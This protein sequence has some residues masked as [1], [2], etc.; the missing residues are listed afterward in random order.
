MIAIIIYGPPGSGKG[1]QAK[2]IADKLGLIHFDTGKYIEQIIYNQAN[3]N[4]KIIQQQRKLFDSGALCSSDWVF[5][6]VSQKIRQLALVGSSIIF[7]GSPRTMPEAFG[8]SFISASSK[9][10]GSGKKQIGLMQILEKYY[11]K[12]NIFVFGIDVSSKNS[13]KRNS[14]RLICSV[15]GIQLLAV[16]KKISLKTCPFCGAELYSRTLDKPEIIK[17]RLK[18]YKDMTMPIFEELKK[19]TY[20]I[21][22]INGEPSPGKVMQSILK[23][24]S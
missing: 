19:R 6:I 13:I 10:N 8:E 1:T 9:Q 20:R 22:R 11:G 3:K 23:W 21:I 7:S 18:K 17:I 24:L 15:C 2:L 12:K 16:F 14:S 4:D 5:K